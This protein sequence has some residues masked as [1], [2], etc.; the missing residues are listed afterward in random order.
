MR[1]RSQ[2]LVLLLATT[3]LPWAGC[4]YVRELE[5]ALREGQAQTLRSA[6][7]AMA[8]VVEP[9]ASAF[10]P[11]DDTPGV[12]GDEFYV[13]RLTRAPEVDGFDADWPL[14]DT[15]RQR[16]SDAISWVRVGRTE[17]HLFVFVSVIDDV[18]LTADPVLTA[19][20]GIAV[21]DRIVVKTSF[22]TPEATSRLIFA[23][24]APGSFTPRAADA[25]WRATAE[26]ADTVLAHW[27]PRRDGYQV[28]IRMP[29]GL[30]G[31]RLGIGFVDVDVPGEP[32]REI[33]SWSRGYLPGRLVE[34]RPALAELLEHNLPPGMRA[35]LVD[36]AGWRLA[37][38]GRLAPVPRVEPEDSL[39][40]AMRNRVFEWW[41]RGDEP[42]RPADALN[43][44][45]RT[46]GSEIEAANQGDTAMARYR[47]ADG[48]V[49]AVAVPLAGGGALLLEQGSAEIITLTNRALTGLLALALGIMGLFAVLLLGYASWLSWRIAR[50]SRAARGALGPRGELTVSLPGAGRGDELGDL[51]RSFETLLQRLDGYTSYLRSLGG[52]LSHE[53][54]TP[55]AVVNS[56]LENLLPNAPPAEQ[57]PYLA[58]A[59]AGTARLGN[60]LASLSEATR[61]EDMVRHSPHKRYRPVPVVDSCAHAYQALHTG[62]R[63][64]CALTDAPGDLDG[65]PEL[66]AQALD[67][68]I[69]N[70][71]EFC[72]ADGLIEVRLTQ[73]QGQWILSVTNEGAALP[74]AAGSGVTLFDSL[75]SH[76]ATP[77]TQP[78]LGLGLYIVRLVA[79][80]H[81]GY[82]R[83]DD[84]E[85]GVCVSLHMPV[86]PL[87]DR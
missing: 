6:A 73:T 12:R 2:L 29:L 60:I 58:R 62:H 56:S 84:V 11:A 37:S 46:A 7:V 74:A 51:A 1:L 40:A 63:W 48:T 78:H 20:D 45:A 72:P 26:R 52:K 87:A 32:G 81:G 75:V 47:I 57:A 28:E 67:K 23:A 25:R 8:R 85:H 61:A 3:L 66:L 70:A 43:A 31:K 80:F 44:L 14:E 16:L 21:R 33:L 35:E 82:A 79:E 54:K 59:R 9:A 55:L 76:R 4:Q 19:P 69:D 50:L 38:A 13:H 15:A 42:S 22:D 71:V 41:L 83:A 34:A 49:L 65:S 53:L 17:R 30:V 86:V 10:T 68:L 39:W 5:D 36:A 24:E 64:R 18:V 77:S 27:Q